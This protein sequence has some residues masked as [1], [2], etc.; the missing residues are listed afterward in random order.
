MSTNVPTFCCHFYFERSQRI[1]DIGDD[2]KVVMLHTTL[3]THCEMK[4]L[5]G[6]STHTHE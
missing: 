3:N 5:I 1:M 4:E 6:E 2:I